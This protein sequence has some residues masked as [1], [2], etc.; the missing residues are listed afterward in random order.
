MSEQFSE[1]FG[2]LNAKVK[3]AHQRLDKLEILIRDELKTVSENLK[4]MSS[5]FRE[6]HKE[7]DQWISRAKGW[8]AAALLLGGGA[9]G[10]IVTKLFQ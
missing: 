6:A 4:E 9:I 1:K 7:H 5:E 2:E 3:A 10:T 8:A